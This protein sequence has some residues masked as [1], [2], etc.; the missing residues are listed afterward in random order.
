MTGAVSHT[1]PSDQ[2]PDHRGYQ[3]GNGATV[4]CE[5]DAT[6]QQTVSN[7]KRR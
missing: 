4:V 2:N 6:S 3:K 7:R 1:G 5:E